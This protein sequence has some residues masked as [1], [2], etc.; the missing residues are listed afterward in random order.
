ENKAYPES[1]TIRAVAT[2]IAGTLL[3]SG[4]IGNNGGGYA[5]VGATNPDGETVLPPLAPPPPPKPGAPNNSTSGGSGG[6]SYQNYLNNNN[7]GGGGSSNFGS[8]DLSG[9]GNEQGDKTGSA[10][11]ANPSDV[12]E[13]NTIRSAAINAGWTEE[14]IANLLKRRS[15]ST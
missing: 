2:Q 9:K 4:V 8:D 6:D 11:Q 3:D 15:E 12:A 10:E 14:E 5:D 13:I 7:I 1:Q